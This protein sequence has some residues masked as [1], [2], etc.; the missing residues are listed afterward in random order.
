M[1]KKASKEVLRFNDAK[2]VKKIGT[3]S[4]GILFCNTRM[5]ESAELKA[6]GH[7]ADT[8][9]IADFT[10]VN[11]KVPIIDQHSPLALSIAL[12]MHYCVLPHRGVESQ[13]RMCLQFA[14]IIKARSIFDKISKDCVYCK[15]LRGKY[16]EQV[17][18]P[19]DSSQVT[20]SPVFYFTMVDLWG[21]IQSFVPG[22][23]KVTRSTSNKPHEIYFLVFACCATGTVNVQVIE[24][25]DTGFC[26]DG[27][28]RFFSETTVPKFIFADEEGGLVKYI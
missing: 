28:N 2:Q 9:N 25:R 11:F 6:V 8:I 18:G 17:M 1:F 19:F 13:H 5:L 10:G 26:L 4:N 12:H 22:Y 3:E 15:K 27:M 21:P 23:E 14:S 20:I 16:L 24:G 7:L